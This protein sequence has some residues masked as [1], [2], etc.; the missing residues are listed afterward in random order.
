MLKFNGIYKVLKSKNHIRLLPLILLAIFWSTLEAI[1]PFIIKLGVDALSGVSTL[2]MPTHIKSLET[3]LW[4]YLFLIFVTELAMRLCNYL[5]RMIVPELCLQ[6]EQRVIIGLLTQSSKQQIR[7]TNPKSHH[8]K[9][10]S[11]SF[12]TVIRILIYGLLPVT[13]SYLITAMILT[14]I[15]FQAAGLY[16]LWFL[17]MICISIAS[18]KQLLVLSESVLQHQNHYLNQT[19]DT[20]FN[21]SVVQRYYKEAVELRRIKKYQEQYYATQ[22]HEN[23]YIVVINVIRSVLTLLLISSTILITLQL[24]SANELKLGS[25]AFLMISTLSMR[26]DTWVASYFLMDILKH[27]GI[28]KASLHEIP[29]NKEFISYS[30][31]KQKLLGDIELQKIDFKYSDRPSLFNKLDLRIGFKEKVAIIGGS[32]AGKSTLVDIILGQSKPQGGQIRFNNKLIRDDNKYPVSFFYIEQSEG[33]FNRSI[34]ENMIYGLCKVPSKKSIAQAILDA[35]AT[36]IYDNSKNVLHKE[37]SE[38]NNLSGGEKQKVLLTRCFL[39]ESELI[40]LD[41]ATSALDIKSECEIVKTL[42][43]RKSNNTVIFVGHRMPV[44]KYFDRII[45]MD[46]GRIIE[47]G[48]HQELINHKGAYYSLCQAKY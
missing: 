11:Y 31:A 20:L 18:K 44:I 13:W 17:G 6:L 42:I 43:Q 27:L 14:Q 36:L 26:R 48:S 37:Y 21:L 29:K 28:L 30:Q 15:S 16:I 12:E 3:L 9:N 45:V 38:I 23:K 19:H 34:Y 39:H 33:F 46:K 1:I 40:V 10:I 41:E 2:T 47:D 25:I 24:L 32:G 8:I 7:T 35:Q 5:Y 22:D 4:I